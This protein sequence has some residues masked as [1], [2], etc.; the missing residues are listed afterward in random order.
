MFVAVMGASNGISTRGLKMDGTVGQPKPDRAAVIRISLI[1]VA[2]V[3]VCFLF[4]GN[5]P[6]S[7]WSEFLKGNSAA[8]RI[9][10]L[11]AFAVA[12]LVGALIASITNHFRKRIQP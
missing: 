9:I 12:I 4:A 8:F 7:L 3:F 11:V 2:F 1:T 5:S 10:A 6:S